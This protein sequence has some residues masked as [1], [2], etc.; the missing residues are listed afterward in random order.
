M[1]EEAN[2]YK[3]LIGIWKF[4]KIYMKW[5]DILFIIVNE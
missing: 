5:H 4:K 3:K 2:L 1:A